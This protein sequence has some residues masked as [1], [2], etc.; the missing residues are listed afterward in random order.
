MHSCQRLCWPWG[1]CRTKPDSLFSRSRAIAWPVALLLNI[2]GG[3]LVVALEQLCDCESKQTVIDSLWQIRGDPQAGGFRFFINP[4]YEKSR[5]SLRINNFES[6]SSK[7]NDVNRTR[8][9][10]QPWWFGVCDAAEAMFEVEK[11]RT[12]DSKAGRPQEMATNT[13]TTPS[14]RTSAASR[15]QVLR[16]HCQRTAGVGGGSSFSSRYRHP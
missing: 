12:S 15:F 14:R 11:R 9:T 3:I 1:A 16:C 13:P 5:I 2:G 10:S 4:L 8:S 7:V 6:T